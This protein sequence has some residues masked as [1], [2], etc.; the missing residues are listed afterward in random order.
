MK[1]SEVGDGAQLA[2]SDEA[3]GNP[4]AHHESLQRP[5]LSVLAAGDSCPVTLCVDAPPAEVSADP[6][7]RDGTESFAGKAADLLQ[8]VPRIAGTLQ[9]LD[10]LRFRFLRRRFDYLGHKFGK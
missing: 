8:T 9:T 7:R 3:V 6:F 10:S 5:A 2:G 1:L 4:D